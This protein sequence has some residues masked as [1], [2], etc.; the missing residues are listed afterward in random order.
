MRPLFT[1]VV[2]DYCDGLARPAEYFSGFVVWQP[3]RSREGRAAYVFRSRTE[4][5]LWRSDRS[6]EEFRIREV[7]CE[8]PLAWRVSTGTLEGVEVADRL[9][10]IY[11]DKRFEPA[12]NRAFLAHSVDSEAA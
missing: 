7:L 1:S 9:F 8:F 2:C 4:A 3:E 12:P 6:L 10:E 5:E 11:E